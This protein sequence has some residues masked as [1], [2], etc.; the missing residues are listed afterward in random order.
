M[1]ASRYVP[2]QDTNQN[3][4]HKIIPIEMIVRKIVNV[5]RNLNEQKFAKKEL[6]SKLCRYIFM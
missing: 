4:H 2:V 6:I 1:N 3:W 5:V